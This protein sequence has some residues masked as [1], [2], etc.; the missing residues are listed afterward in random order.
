MQ[1][2]Q[3]LETVFLNL[4]AA[5]IL[6]CLN[7]KMEHYSQFWNLQ[8]LFFKAANFKNQ[9]RIQSIYVTLSRICIFLLQK[10]ARTKLTFLQFLSISAW[11]LPYILYKTIH[12][13]NDPLGQTHSPANSDHYSNSLESCF[14]FEILKSGEIRTDVQT[15]NS[16]NSNH[17]V[18]L[19]DQ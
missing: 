19:V 7:S 3:G 10:Y 6:L 15:V 9:T 16:E 4:F 2:L 8:T 11:L 1:K 12:T 14:V 5:V 18:G 13:I 17:R